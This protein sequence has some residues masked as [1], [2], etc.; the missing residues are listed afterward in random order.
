MSDDLR[1]CTQCKRL[2]PVVKFAWKN[3]E[4]G[5]RHSYCKVCLKSKTREHYYRNPAY[6]RE[7]NKRSREKTAAWLEKQKDFPCLDCGKRYPP[8]VLDFDHRDG[9]EKFLEVSKMVGS[10]SIKRLEEEVAKCDIVCSNCHRIRTHGGK[11]KKK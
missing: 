2:L 9:E 6:Y 11:K 5:K 1:T 7:R 3:K 10:Y 8:Y 4:Q